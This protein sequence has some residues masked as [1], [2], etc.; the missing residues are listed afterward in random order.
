MPEMSGTPSA[1]LGGVHVF[2]PSL[3][4]SSALDFV[5]AI[6]GADCEDQREGHT[7]REPR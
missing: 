2:A 5:W 4:A 3:A 7:G 1:V 6:A